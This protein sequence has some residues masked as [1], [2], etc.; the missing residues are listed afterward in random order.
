VARH[1]KLVPVFVLILCTSACSAVPSVPTVLRSPSVQSSPSSSEATGDRPPACSDGTF[2]YDPVGSRLLLVTCVDQVHGQDSEQ[3]WSW[4]GKV[5]QLV[6][7]DGPP[8]VVVTGVAYD[9]QRN[10]LV[11]YG[12]VPLDSRTCIRQTWE[13]NGRSWRQVASAGGANPPA[14]DH[15]KM[16]Y[17]ATK[18][19][20]IL[21]GG[22]DEQQRLSGETWA[23][24]GSRWRRVATAGPDGRAHLGLVYE[25]GHQLTFLYGGF[26]GSHVFDDFWEWNGSAWRELDIPGPGPRSHAA[27]AVTGAGMLIFGGST[28]ASTFR[29]LANDTWFLTRGR[30]SKRPL[31]TAPSPRGSPALAYDPGRH[32]WVLYGGFGPDGTELAD[33]WEWTGSAW[34]C[35]DRCE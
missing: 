32:T 13:W 16:A 30:W 11:R 18:R 1:A 23:W 17:D 12:G 10:V 26:D 9:T 19:L 24:D 27:I 15:M 22:G 3:I 21:F 29:T 35:V 34:R 20:T 33:T 28:G 5:W 6:D 8:P 2:V 14:C 25:D 7:G 31:A 4:D